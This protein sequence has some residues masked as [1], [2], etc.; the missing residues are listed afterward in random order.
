MVFLR[1]GRLPWL[2]IKIT[3]QMTRREKYDLVTKKKME[4]EIADITLGFPPEMTRFYEYCRSGM[5]FYDVPD[6]GYLKSLL[7]SVIFKENFK[8][9]MCFSWQ[10]KQSTD[11]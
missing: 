5:D 9:V 7:Y 11:L 6:Y 3:P 1:K 2:R 10:L 4:T 8:T